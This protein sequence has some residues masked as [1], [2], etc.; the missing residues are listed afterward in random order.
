MSASPFA[1]LL[2]PSHVTSV[3]GKTGPGALAL[4]AVY[5]AVRLR[6]AHAARAPLHPLV[7]QRVD[8]ARWHRGLSIALSEL[9]ECCCR[10]GGEEGGFSSLLDS[11]DA[12]RR[13]DQLG[14]RGA[15]WAM[16]RHIDRLEKDAASLV[17][18]AAREGS[19][20][21]AFRATAYASEEVVPT[22]G[23]HLRDMMHNRGLAS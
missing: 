8:L 2:S 9:A 5:G 18:K 19:S 10:G 16:A 22:I 21:D 3:L 4:A 20:P 6:A 11:A 23:K 13:L 1:S 14:Q 12:I 15:E 7:A 17:E